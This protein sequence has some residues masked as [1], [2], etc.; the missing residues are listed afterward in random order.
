MSTTATLIGELAS[1]GPRVSP[2]I[3]RDDAHRD[4]LVPRGA[5]FAGRPDLVR[6]PRESLVL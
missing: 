6:L 1:C 2:R 5:R 3:T 4:A